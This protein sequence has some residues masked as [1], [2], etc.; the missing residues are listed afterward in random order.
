[1]NP[2]SFYESI[3]AAGAI[4]IGFCGTFLSFRIQREANY[5]R[6]PALS[7]EHGKARDVLIGLS[8][9]T[10]AFL[11]L[12]LATLSSMV[13]GFPLPLLALIGTACALA[14]P[15]IIAGWLIATLILNRLVLLG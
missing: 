13:F 2:R 1:M 11:L 3:I 6:Q 12:I 5:Y 14:N 9:F 7:F 15:G 8:H 4:T 10:N